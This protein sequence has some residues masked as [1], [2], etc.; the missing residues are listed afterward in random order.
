MAALA[1]V[2]RLRQPQ[3]AVNIWPGYVDALSA[4]LM[5]VIF[6]LLV[7]TLAQFFLTE[8]LSGRDKELEELTA[9]YYADASFFKTD[10]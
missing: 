3:R 1:E 6:V 7:F 8:I 10:W 2:E 5:L 9:P 4:L